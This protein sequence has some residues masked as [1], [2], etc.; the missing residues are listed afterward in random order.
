[1]TKIVIG[2]NNKFDLFKILVHEQDKFKKEWTVEKEISDENGYTSDCVKYTILK[3][4]SMV[5]APFLFEFL[6]DS[7]GI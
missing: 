5:D 7:Y 4:V 6:S 3:G 1:M 2:Q